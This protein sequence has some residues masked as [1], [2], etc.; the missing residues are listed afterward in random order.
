MQKRGQR[1]GNFWGWVCLFWMWNLSAMKIPLFL[2]FGSLW[3]WTVMESTVLQP[4]LLPHSA[5][6]LS[7]GPLRTPPK[8]SITLQVPLRVHI[9][10]PC[11][12]TSSQWGET[13][14][15][16][17]SNKSNS[18]KFF[19]AWDV[20]ILIRLQTQQLGSISNT[21]QRILPKSY[22]CFLERKEIL[23]LDSP[24]AELM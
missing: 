20:H 4:Q 3:F 13:C 12:A 9:L 23:C 8:T 1:K 15:R 14:C 21:K 18:H 24:G 16:Q 22:C 11:S 2:F 10:P 17:Q 7:A 19:K 6:C 5:H